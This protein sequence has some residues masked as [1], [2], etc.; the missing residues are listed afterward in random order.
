MWGWSLAAEIRL[1]QLLIW[2]SSDV[3]MAKKVN[4]LLTI[5]P[6]LSSQQ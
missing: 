4:P 1:K 5:C 2:D 3:R 6:L